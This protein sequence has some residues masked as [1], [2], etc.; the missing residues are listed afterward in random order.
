MMKRK[1]SCYTILY[2]KLIINVGCNYEQDLIISYSQHYFNGCCV[3]IR[4]TDKNKG[5]LL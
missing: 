2:K 5:S 4:F 3:R 1:G